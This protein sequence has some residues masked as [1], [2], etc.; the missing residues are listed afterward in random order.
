MSDDTQL[1]RQAILGLAA[2][3]YTT[4]TDELAALDRIEARILQ[5]EAELAKPKNQR[6]KAPL[7]KDAP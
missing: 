3:A 2:E 1:L 7:R 5:L 4:A 6:W